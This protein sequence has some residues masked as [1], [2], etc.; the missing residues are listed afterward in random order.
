MAIIDIHEIPES[1]ELT[2]TPQTATSHWV[3]EGLF[4]DV[5][6][7]NLALATIPDTV[8]HPLGE[9]YRDDMQIVE[10]GFQVYSITVTYSLFKKEVGTYRI[11]FDTLGGTV[12]VKGGV[13]QAVFPSGN[14]THNGLI[15]VKGDDVEGADIVIPAMRIIVHFSHPGKY[16]TAERIRTLSRLAGSVDNAGFFGWDPYE[17]LFLGAQGSQTTDVSNQGTESREEVAYHFAMSENRTSFQVAGITVAAK[18]GWDVAWVKWREEPEGGKASNQAEYV[19][20]VRVYRE[21]NLKA[22]LGFG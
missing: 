6:V 13:H 5:A 22:A 10:D 8:P 20:V 1:R 4:D 7:G 21:Q 19:N 18:K 9:V 2:M 14:P 17:T 3:C 12:H 16:L 15:G 11:E